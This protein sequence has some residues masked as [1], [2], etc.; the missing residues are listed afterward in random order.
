LPLLSRPANAIGRFVGN[1]LEKGSGLAK[2]NPGILGEVVTKDPALPWRMGS[3][4]AGKLYD[5][6]KDAGEVRKALKFVSEENPSPL[7]PKLFVRRAMQ[8]V[9]DGS[10]NPK[11]ALRARQ[12]LDSIKNQLA[13]DAYHTT[14]DIFDKIAKT[15]FDEA[16]KAFAK[17]MKSDAL[18]NFWGINAGGSPSML[19]QGATLAYPVTGPIFSPLAQSSLASGLGYARQAALPLLD[20]PMR[21]GVGLNAL[22]RRYT[23]DE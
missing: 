8:Y 12:E 4:D 22:R 15:K 21:G 20:N 23:D 6:V 9:K 14:R 2:K 18:T 17:G 10:I 1:T 5:K 3:E 7:N 16:D 19:K 11:E 13:D